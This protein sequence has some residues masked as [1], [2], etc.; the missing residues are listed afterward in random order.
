MKPLEMIATSIGTITAIEE[1]KLK[2]PTDGS[3]PPDVVNNAVATQIS[4]AGTSDSAMV[5]TKDQ[6]LICGH[7]E[8]LAVFTVTSE[9]GATATANLMCV[10]LYDPNGRNTLFYANWNG[11]H[12]NLDKL[13]LSD[14][15]MCYNVG[16]E[17]YLLNGEA[18]KLYDEARPMR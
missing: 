13:K 17:V 12:I 7:D 2:L 14:G 5:K 3:Y 11:E 4:I 18:Y 10:W 6:L 8:K 16:Q 9:D 15:N 1:V